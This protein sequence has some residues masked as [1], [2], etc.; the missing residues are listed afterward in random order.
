M[1]CVDADVD[2]DDDDDEDDEDEDEKDESVFTWFLAKHKLTCSTK[3]A[4]ITTKT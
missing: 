4:I 1:V 3:I 2:E